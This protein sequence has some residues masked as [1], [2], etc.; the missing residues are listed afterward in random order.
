MDGRSFDA[1]PPTA[2]RTVLQPQCATPAAASAMNNG[3]GDGYLPPPPPQTLRSP[4]S[5]GSDRFPL[6]PRVGIVPPPPRI[7]TA[8][9]GPG[10]HSPA[11]ASPYAY[12]SPVTSLNSALSPHAPVASPSPLSPRADCNS[13]AYRSA[14]GG[15]EYNPQQW[16]R[17]SPAA[18]GQYRPH[19]TLTVP[20]PAPRMLDD[21]GRK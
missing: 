12:S 4:G 8:F 15:M 18:V 2:G 13:M 21:S 11:S 1:V 20:A 19:A 14:S 17:G 16:G 10:S 3:C 9:A 7:T 6:S 5:A